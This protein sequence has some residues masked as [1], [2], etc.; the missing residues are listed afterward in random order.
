MTHLDFV[1]SIIVRGRQGNISVTPPTLDCTYT[2]PAAKNNCAA[3]CSTC[4]LADIDDVTEYRRIVNYI[5]RSPS[6]W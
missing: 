6:D 1:L 5:P 2:Q 4:R 3:A